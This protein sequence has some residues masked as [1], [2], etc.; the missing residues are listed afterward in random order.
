MNSDAPADGSY[1]G[2]FEGRRGDR[3]VGWT[4]DVTDP[5]RSLKVSLSVAGE[6]PVEA[7]AD[8]HRA[9]VHEI[10]HPNGYAGFSAP[11]H[12]FPAGSVIAC[13]WSD[14][15]IA[16]PGSP[17]YPAGMQHVQARADHGFIQ[18]VV[19]TPDPGDWRIS[20]HVFEPEAPLRRPVLGLFDGPR[21]LAQARATLYRASSGGDGLHGFLLH[22]P[23]GLADRKLRIVDLDRDMV[24]IAFTAGHP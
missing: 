1:A 18:I 8:R 11:A 24:L 13:V 10:G 9:D 3:I 20:G 19:D 12:A 7:T 2:F 22:R 5:R 14:T 16:L 6:P 21:R 15:G 23:P 17:Y 4:Y